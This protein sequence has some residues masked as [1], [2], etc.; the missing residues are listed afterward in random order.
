MQCNGDP[1]EAGGAAAESPRLHPLSEA[2]GYDLRQRL[3][4]GVH[5]DES[6]LLV[7]V[8][9]AQLADHGMQ[10]RSGSAD[11]HDDVVR[12]QRLPP[13]GGVDDVRSPVQALRG[14]EHL[15]ME[16]VG[17]HHVIADGDA[18]HVNYPSP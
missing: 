17:D 12:V 6:S 1:G 2:V 8:P 5:A 14:T 3:G 10:F 11:V 13:K 4:G 9:V 16:A 18:E 7:Q 15:T